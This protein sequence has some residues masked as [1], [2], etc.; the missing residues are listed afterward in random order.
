MQFTH[1]PLERCKNKGVAAQSASVTQLRGVKPSNST[2]PAGQLFL[3]LEII[4]HT[5][6]HYNLSALIKAGQLSTQAPI[7]HKNKKILPNIIFLNSE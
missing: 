6:T 3:N 4:N 2:S 1:L 7:Y 5:A